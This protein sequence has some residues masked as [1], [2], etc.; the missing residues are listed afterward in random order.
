[1]VNFKKLRT[2]N[3]NPKPID[4]LEV[5][6]RLP[7]PPG[8]NDLYTSQSEVLRNWFSNRTKSDTVLKLHTGGGKTL[9]GLLIAQSTLNETGLPVLYL[10][11]T[12]QLVGQ[13]LERAKAVGISAVPYEAGQEINS[14]FLNG[15]AI[16]IA[17]YKALFNGKSKFKIRGAGNSVMVGA[18]ILDDAHAAFT[19][20]RDAFTLEISSREQGEIYN[21]LASIFRTSFQEIDKVGTFDDIVSQNEYGVLEV[22][23]WAWHE[24][25]DAVRVLL[26]EHVS[27]SFEW[28]LL[29]DKLHLCHAIVS[30]DSF[31]ITPIFPLVDQFPT[32][33]EAPRR[34]YMSA[35][36]AD[37]SDIIRTFDASVESVHAPLSSRSL[38]GISERMILIP[39]LMP[40]KLDVRE[41][42]FSILKGTASKNLGSVVLVPSDK[43]SQSWNTVANVVKGPV[44]VSD[45][46]RKLQSGDRNEPYVFSNRY[47]GI[48]LPGDACRVLVLCGLPLGTSNYEIFRAQALH[49]GESIVR[50]IAQRIEQGIGRGA[51][52]AGDHCVVILAG[53]D[54]TGWISRDANFKMLTVATR[55]QLDMGIE[56]S[57]AVVDLPDFLGTLDRSLNRDSEWI[58][59]HAETLADRVGS[60]DGDV[61]NFDH[62]AAER[63]AFNLW[64]DN[65]PEKSIST[66]ERCVEKSGLDKQTHGWL[67]QFAARISDHWGNKERAEKLQQD[68]YSQNRGL[69]RSKIKPPY[70]S[71]LLPLE[72]ATA[73]VKQLDSYH[74][75]RGFLRS[76]D[77]TVGYLHAQSTS[78][79]FEKSLE[80][81]GTMIGFNCERFDKHGEGPDVL[82]IL[83]NGHGWVIEAKSRK[84]PKNSLTKGEHGQLL[85]AAEWFA[86][87]YPGLTP[88]RVSVHPTNIA[89]KAASAEDSYAL[90]YP[91]LSLLI[92]E[93]RTFLSLLCESQ[94][95]A[96][97]LVSYCA[98]LLAKSNI[99][100]DRVSNYL[101]LFSNS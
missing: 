1:M 47:D 33:A 45:V 51:R 76:F 70:R 81:L 40:F 52:G 29:R 35:T 24:K 101:K 27:T 17:T 56:I 84:K 67:L 97:E 10:A 89:T 82:W 2:E 86:K 25:I 44:E 66:I 22:P 4:P 74:I 42:I 26:K 80:E 54:L 71:M 53:S 58:E 18:V 12:N 13:T 46:V 73:I 41:S 68:A 30:R 69:L 75:R 34:I 63:R 96:S 59:Y 92:S 83:P 39:E 57:K 64:R 6:R 32:F 85:V 37:D 5:F 28:P 62:V 79:Q 98:D 88:V 50:M 15:Q 60:S 61:Q 11:P 19:E 14:D 7:K 77:E 78:N 93:A 43:A 36:I 48:D 65:H 55:A 3:R 16:M 72:Q 91:S 23:Y 90:T 95:P 21:Y 87:M 38:A 100:A 9:V 94:V 31:S 49:G 99:H 20:V 8:I